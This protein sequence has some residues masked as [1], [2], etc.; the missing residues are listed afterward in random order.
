MSDEKIKN[1]ENERKTEKNILKKCIEKITENDNYNKGNIIN[2]VNDF[3]NKKNE[4]ENSE[5][6]LININNNN[7]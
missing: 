7:I 6:E 1:L 5:F 3:I 2:P 4:K